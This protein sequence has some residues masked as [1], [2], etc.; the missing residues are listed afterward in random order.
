VESGS[1]YTVKVS[2][3]IQFLLSAA[4]WWREILLSRMRRTALLTLYRS[5]KIRLKKVT[6]ELM[7][8]GAAS[9]SGT[10]VTQLYLLQIQIEDE[11]IQTPLDGLSTQQLL[12]LHAATFCYVHEV[13]DLMQMLRRSFQRCE[14]QRR[15]STVARGLK[16]GKWDRKG[17]LRVGGVALKDTSTKQSQ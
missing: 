7:R 5:I 4:D 10:A 15:S 14:R 13:W 1:Q 6:E 2:T 11:L 9:S 8:E 3:Q 17:L 12:H 16:A